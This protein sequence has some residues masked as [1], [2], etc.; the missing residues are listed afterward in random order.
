MFEVCLKSYYM[1]LYHMYFYTIFYFIYLFLEMYT[2]TVDTLSTFFALH[3]ECEVFSVM[4]YC[5]I[6]FTLC[7]YKYFNILRTFSY[8]LVC[9][10]RG[11]VHFLKW[12][13]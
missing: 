3:F 1:Y 12:Q 10:F 11:K 4:E 5:F 2:F 8:M 13:Q 9:L 6:F 7:L